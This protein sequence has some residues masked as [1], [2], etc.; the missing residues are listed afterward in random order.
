MFPAGSRLAHSGEHAGM[1]VHALGERPTA[2]TGHKTVA[3]SLGETGGSPVLG[4][5]RCET[6]PDAPRYGISALVPGAT[7]SSRR[8]PTGASLLVPGPKSVSLG[9]SEVLIS[10]SWRERREPEPLRHGESR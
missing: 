5:D 9:R 10:R 2:K 1:T 8:Y 6:P 3:V 4:P 7:G